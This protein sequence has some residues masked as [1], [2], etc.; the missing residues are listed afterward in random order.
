MYVQ[1]GEV[2]GPSCRSLAVVSL[3]THPIQHCQ[4]PNS[5]STPAQREVNTGES[6]IIKYTVE[7]FIAA[8]HLS[9]HLLSEIPE[10]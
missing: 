6:L 1:L 3:S 7:S 4:T 10:C 8:L 9:Q 5:E 2:I